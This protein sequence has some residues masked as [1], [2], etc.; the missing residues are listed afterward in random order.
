VNPVSDDV[1][2]ILAMLPPPTHWSYESVIG[3]VRGSTGTVRV[4]RES[5]DQDVHLLVLASGFAVTVSTTGR[6][7]VSIHSPNRQDLGA[8]AVLARTA[9]KYA[10]EHTV[11]LELDFFP[12][13]GS[14]MFTFGSLDD[15]D[16]IAADFF[17]A[18]LLPH[19][20]WGR[21]DS[22]RQDAGE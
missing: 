15:A 11:S 18:T 10:R 12:D 14:A 22:A 2:V 17:A 20:G 9:Q 5:V 13:T 3:A 21:A 6:A 16:E 8:A 7:I 19:G 1:G 4:E